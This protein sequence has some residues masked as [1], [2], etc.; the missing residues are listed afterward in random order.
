MAVFS[1]FLLN[2]EKYFEL[3]WTVVRKSQEIRAIRPIL[4]IGHKKAREKM[5]AIF[6]AFFRH[7]KWTLH[8]CVQIA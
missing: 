4:K 1:P 5:C 7:E 3:P 8:A 6:R 2:V